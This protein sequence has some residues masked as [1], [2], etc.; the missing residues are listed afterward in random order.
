MGNNSSEIIFSVY[1][2]IFNFSFLGGRGGGE[3][4]LKFRSKNL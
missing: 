3:G 2:K 1:E 4:E